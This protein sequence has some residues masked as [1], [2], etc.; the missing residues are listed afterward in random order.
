MRFD[1]KPVKL[2]GRFVRLEPLAMRHASGLLAAAAAPA[3]WTYLPVPQPETLADVKKLIAEALRGQKT[4]L[5]VPFVTIR[6]ADK[7]VV[8]STRYLDIRRPHRALEIGWTWLAAD[9]QRTPVNTEAK[10]L[11]LRHAFEVQGAVRVQLKT[12][13]R[14]EQSRRAIL[15]LGAVFEGIL[16]NYQT[17]AHDEYVRNTAMYSITQKEWPDVKARLEAKLLR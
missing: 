1:P 16:R 8:G 3:I 13:A 7:R 11:M 14:N 4:G 15:G 12:D 17:R 9:A 6:R 5:E 10:Y 2:D